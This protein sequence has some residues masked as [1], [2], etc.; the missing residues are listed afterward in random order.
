MTSLHS[1]SHLLHL[2]TTKTRNTH[3]FTTLREHA[4]KVDDLIF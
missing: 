2:W 3:A 4:A 1:L